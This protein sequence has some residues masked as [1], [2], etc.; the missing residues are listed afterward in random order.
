MRRSACPDQPRSLDRGRRLCMSGRATDCLAGRALPPADEH[1]PSGSVQPPPLGSAWT[2][3]AC[4]TVRAGRQRPRD[5]RPHFSGRS[6][7]R[8]SVAGSSSR[9]CRC[10]TP[11]T[12]LVDASVNG[13]GQLLPVDPIGCPGTPVT[14]SMTLD[15]SRRVLKD[16]HSKRP[17]RSTRR[18][19]HKPR[20]GCCACWRGTPPTVPRA[21]PAGAAEEPELSEALGRLAAYDM[22]TLTGDSVSVHRLVRTVTRSPD[23]ADPHRQPDDIATARDTATTTRATNSSQRLNG[24]DHPT[25]SGYR[26]PTTPQPEP[27]PSV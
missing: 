26:A 21:L 9:R 8:C 7:S 20:D 18:S 16:L 1:V 4:P 17:T 3:P 24:P 19:T 13:I 22:I 11:S 12:E 14:P 15:L 27:E 5:M 23:S 6:G 25:P 2:T 10:W